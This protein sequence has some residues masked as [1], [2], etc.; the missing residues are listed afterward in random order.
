MSETLTI[1][2]FYGIVLA[3]VGLW[4]HRTLWLS[5]VTSKVSQ[6]TSKVNGA[7]EDACDPF[8]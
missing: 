7:D 5:G 6:G 1:F 8:L 4:E 2:I 3:I